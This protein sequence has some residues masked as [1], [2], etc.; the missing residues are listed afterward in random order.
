V[1]TSEALLERIKT[2]LLDARDAPLL[3]GTPRRLRMEAV[4]GRT[5]NV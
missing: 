1:T 4:A 3:T 2:V 5:A